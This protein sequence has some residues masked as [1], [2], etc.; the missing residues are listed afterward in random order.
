VTKIAVG[1]V[2][3]AAY[4]EEESQEHRA[5]ELTS[6]DGRDE[7]G[8]RLGRAR[9]TRG[10]AGEVGIVAGDARRI[11]RPPSFDAGVRV[12][13]Y[14]CHVRISATT[15]WPKAAESWQQADQ[16]SQHPGPGGMAADSTAAA[17]PGYLSVDDHEL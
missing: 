13:R 5:E 4:D 17:N 1:E 3:Q 10:R 6:R 12:T 11:S 9:H 16:S 7:S 2:L 14:F 8:E 15:P